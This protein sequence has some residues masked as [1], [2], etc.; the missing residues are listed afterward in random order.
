L[1]RVRLR[2]FYLAAT[3]DKRPLHSRYFHQIRRDPGLQSRARFTLKQ[4]TSISSSP[5]LLCRQKTMNFQFF[6]K[7]M[8][9]IA[10]KNLFLNTRIAKAVALT[11]LASSVLSTSMSPAIANDRYDDDEFK[12]EM[13]RTPNLV[14]FPAC[15][16]N[17]SAK[18]T[19]EPR[20]EAEEM[21]VKVRGLPA[22]VKFNLF[23]IQ[24]PNPPA[25]MA[26][27]QGEVQTNKHGRGAAKFAG[28]FNTETF[29]VSNAANPA[30]VIFNNPP[31]PDA[32][33]GP[34]TGPIHT[35]HLGMWFD[36]PQ[37][38]IKAGCPGNTT[39]FNGAHNAG[40]QILNTSNFPNLEGPLRSV[41][42]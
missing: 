23:V 30:P 24:Q 11:V 18:V 40:V 22:D 8:N 26:W 5:V 7:V 25:G 36:S 16:P 34:I 1:N 29:I 12:F 27:Y 4:Q 15:L 3:Q 32:A 21:R 39:P 31:F 37:D 19:I 38:A 6:L 13:V 33:V 35:F 41:K 20:G 10:A 14:A 17:A 9:M 28:R 42:P 2:N